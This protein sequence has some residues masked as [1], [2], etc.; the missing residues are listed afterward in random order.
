MAGSERGVRGDLG[1][2]GEGWVAWKCMSASQRG[3]R[4]GS[5]RR[6]SPSY[7]VYVMELERAAGHQQLVRERGSAQVVQVNQL[8][9]F[10]VAFFVWPP[11]FRPPGS[12]WRP[13]FRRR[14]AAPR[15]KILPVL[16]AGKWDHLAQASTL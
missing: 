10:R 5:R 4:G 12:V 15:A 7:S 8:I 13:L 11:L 6:I 3:G 2:R 14:E 16:Q 9:D 1:C